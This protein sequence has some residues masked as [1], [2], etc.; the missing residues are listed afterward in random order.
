MSSFE[1]ISNYCFLGVLT[2]RIRNSFLWHIDQDPP[3][4]TVQVIGVFITILD[5]VVIGLIL[6][7]NCFI[8]YMISAIGPI[9]I[10]ALFFFRKR[11]E[12]PLQLCF[13]FALF[14]PIVLLT[15]Y[16]SLIH[17]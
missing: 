9:A 13:I 11:W 12:A 16:L 7:Q 5:L 14:W 10:F 1:K 4:W 15:L 6:N 2:R 3:G 17:I 8:T